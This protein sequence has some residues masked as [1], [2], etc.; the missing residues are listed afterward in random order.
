MS[1]RVLKIAAVACS[2]NR[3]D[4]TSSFLK[5]LIA[6]H[7]PDG[8][9][10]SIYLLDDQSPDGTANYVATHFPE[11]TVINGSGSLYW[12]GGM[13]KLWETVIAGG[14]EYDFYLLMND[15]IQLYGNA[16]TRLLHSYNLS[17]H[18]ENIVIGTFMSHDGVTI[19]YGGN[20]LI[21]WNSGKGYLVEPDKDEL[22]ECEMGHA[23]LMLVDKATVD[24]IGILSDQ[25]IHSF[26]DWD[27]T[28]RA[29]KNGVKVW[30][31]PG[32]Y[33]YCENDHDAPWLLGASLKKRIKFL[34]SPK[35][36]EYK[37]FIKYTKK[38]FPNSLP[39]VFMSLWF[40]TLVPSVYNRFK[41]R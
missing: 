6:Q 34:Y 14:E 33:G 10:L 8:Y 31:A 25:Y 13:H 23:N 2:Y 17:K 30:V 16:I 22:K 32:Y 27:Y 35:G 19:T 15:D 38:H 21:N 29:V 7:I 20:K 28:L 39:V 41:K 37:S 36:L 40:R 26:A 24:K 18:T 4:K 12:A 5:S 11:V 1:A 3:L 9:E